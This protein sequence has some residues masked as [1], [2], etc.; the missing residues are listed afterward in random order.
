MINLEEREIKFMP[1]SPDD[2]FLRYDSTLHGLTFPIDIDFIFKRFTIDSIGFKWRFNDQVV[3]HLKVKEGSPS[4]KIEVLY[5]YIWK[6][7]LKERDSGIV[8]LTYPDHSELCAIERYLFSSDYIEV[9]ISLIENMMKRLRE[10]H[11][12]K[13][14]GDH[15]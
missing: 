3:Y 12:T 13:K 15:F 6:T 7:F 14:E 9:G 2:Y 11:E 1:T 8:K 5:K 4:K 10:K